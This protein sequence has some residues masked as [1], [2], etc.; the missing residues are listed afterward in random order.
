MRQI[1][2]RA[3]QI[4]GLR[5]ENVEPLQVFTTLNIYNM[6]LVRVVVTNMTLVVLKLLMHTD[7][8]I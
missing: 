5:P 7:C 2:S 1:E 8:S 6:V 4:T 3:A